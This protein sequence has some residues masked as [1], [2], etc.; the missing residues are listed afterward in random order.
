MFATLLDYIAFPAYVVALIFSGLLSLLSLL[1]VFL[2]SNKFLFFC[3]L[4]S[5]TIATPMALIG[6]VTTIIVM[7]IEVQS[8]G[9]FS[10]PVGVTMQ[11]N[12]RL[13]PPMLI[14]DGLLVV[15]NI[16]WVAVWWARFV[17]VPRKIGPGQWLM[18]LG[19]REFITYQ[20]VEGDAE[21]AAD[22]SKPILDEDQE[23]RWSYHKG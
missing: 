20:K 19:T 9:A 2:A 21:V 6:T 11:R 13:I 18:G 17:V 3:S 15:I 8:L 23:E 16:F 4:G 1:M 10:E 7:H 22:I 14:A 12:T 5:S